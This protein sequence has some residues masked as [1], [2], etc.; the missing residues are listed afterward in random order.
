VRPSPQAFKV[1]DKALHTVMDGAAF[2]QARGCVVEPGDDKSKAFAAIPQGS[3][4]KLPATMTVAVPGGGTADK[5]VDAGA[6][7]GRRV[8]EQA[9]WAALRSGLLCASID[10]ET[11]YELS[12][13]TL[14]LV[15]AAMDLA[16]PGL[17]AIV[18]PDAPLRLTITPSASLKA[19]PRTSMADD[20]KGGVRMK[21]AM[22]GLG[23]RVEA[24]MRGRWL[25]LLE[26]V[27]DAVAVM[28]LGIDADGNLRVAIADVEVP[29]VKVADSGLFPAA[30][31]ATIAGPLADVGLSLLLGQPMTFEL[32]IDA[33][34]ASVLKL[35]IQTSVIGL[36]VAGPADDWL[37][38]GIALAAKGA[39]P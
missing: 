17:R 15:A 7:I 10:A 20:G 35:P 37:L 29:D 6:L 30:D 1:L 11:V 33:V 9:L 14:V 22:S 25:T 36:Q 38:V 12:G 8:V 19:L 16:L 3:A 21:A 13:Q 34:V 39:T 27:A 5:G 23:I 4:P 18:P 2:A 24:A 26:L 28:E 32:D 31:M